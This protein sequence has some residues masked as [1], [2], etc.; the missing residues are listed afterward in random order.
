[1]TL[2]QLTLELTTMANGPEA[3]GR[4]PETGRAVFVPF[5]I[6]GETAR[7]EIVEERPTFAR[8]RLL[9]VLTPSPDRVAP[10][11]QHFSECGGCHY[12]HMSYAAQ[13]RWK[14]QIVIDQ[15]ARIGGI[16]S[17]N[18]LDTL[19]SPDPFHYRNHVQFSQSSNGKLG[20]V[21]S[22]KSVDDSVL[23]I[24]E[25]PIARPEI[26]QLFDQ[27]DIEKLDVDRI[28]VRV[29]SDGE[30]M[31]I[32]ESESGEPPDVELDLPISV[33]TVNGDGE[34][35]TMIGSDHLVH[36]I[37]GR[38][39][40]ASPGSFF[41]VNTAMAE[42][43]VSAVTESLALSGGEAVLDLYCGVGLF[44]AFIAPVAARVIG[45]E[46]FAPAARDA[47]I[48]LDE[49]DNA[50]LYESPVELALAYLADHTNLQSSDLRILLDPPRSGC[51]KSVIDHLVALAAPRIVYVSCD[52]ATL[53]RDA[54]R[55]I[56]GGYRLASAQPLDMF[57][58]THHIETIA[59]LER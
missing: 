47:E 23:P 53:A 48:N 46:S 24:V 25:C 12:Q 21:K 3:I 6:P 14:R 40:R 17:P 42:R 55:L 34:S 27:I 30:P 15:L 26:M 29:G 9:E 36:E 39:F 59:V 56:A 28:A 1:M 45:V 32:F 35:L 18:V 52:P 50:E 10:V 57:P 41:Q 38:A 20:F 8:A 5:A 11:C 37:G 54:K 2:R 22:D 13:L 7:V 58:Q 16:D 51:D 44:T 49:F 19:P 33:A 31:L 4:D 43:L